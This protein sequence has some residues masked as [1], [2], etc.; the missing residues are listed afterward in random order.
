[1]DQN[2]DAPAPA[3]EEEPDALIPTHLPDVLPVLPMNEMVIVPGIMAPLVFNDEASIRC[4]DEAAL[5]DKYLCLVA[6][7]PPREDDPDPGNLY[8]TATVGRLLQMLKYPDKSTRVLI[9]GQARVKINSFVQVEPFAFER[10]NVSVK[11]VAG[12]MVE[13]TSGLVAGEK[14]AVSGTFLLKSA[15]RQAE[16]GG[17]H[18]H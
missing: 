2:A 13:V 3:A 18:G 7:Q 4:V 17:G 16:L 9:H 8:G 11:P 12:D 6:Q 15:E 10:R 14:V 5:G 1:M